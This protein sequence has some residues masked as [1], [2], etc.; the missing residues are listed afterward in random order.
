M[1]C[2]REREREI[3][4]HSHAAKVKVRSCLPSLHRVD[5]H[6]DIKLRVAFEYV[7]ELLYFEVNKKKSKT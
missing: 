2:R 5:N 1:L 6:V 4:S 7:K 3:G